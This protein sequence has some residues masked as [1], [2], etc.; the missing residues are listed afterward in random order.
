MLTARSQ[1]DNVSV[2]Y[3]LSSCLSIQLGRPALAFDIVPFI[4]YCP[5]V[6]LLMFEGETN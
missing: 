6:E 5:G 2:E 4:S 1:T 3:L